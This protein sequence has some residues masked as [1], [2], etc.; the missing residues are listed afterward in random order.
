MAGIAFS[1]QRLMTQDRMSSQARGYLHATV[2]A[3][4]PWLLTAAAIALMLG[5]AKDLLS[6]VAQ[7]RFGSVSLLAF[8][9]SLVVASPLAMVLSRVLAD[10]IYVRDVRSVAPRLMQ[11]LAWAFVG[12]AAVAGALFGWWLVLP[13]P[14]RLLG[15]LL[16][17][18]CTGVWVTSSV[19]A[20]LR[21]FSTVTWGFALGLA[22]ALCVAYA[23]FDGWRGEALLLGLVVGLAVTF[24]VLLARVL[25]EFPVH[26]ATP[27]DADVPAALAPLS[28]GP[29]IARHGGL[30]LAGLLYALGLWVDEWIMGYAPGALTAGRGVHHHATYESAMFVASLAVI[31]AMVMLL[32]HLETQLHGAYQG[33]HREVTR[34]GTLR[35]IRRQHGSLLR[36]SGSALRR[37]MLLQ[38]TTVVLAWLAAPLLLRWLGGDE[39]LL[40]VL[41]FGL[42]GAA[43]HGVLIALLTALAYVDRQ[44]WMVGATLT[45]F[46]VNALATAMAA[47]LGP[48]YHGAGYAVA[49]LLAAVVAY[50][51]ASSTLSRLPYVTFVMANE[52]VRAPQRSRAD[53]RRVKAAVSARKAA[54]LS[55]PT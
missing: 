43:F 30:A 19:L 49:A 27:T 11:A 39:A 6:D 38:A 24:F 16:A 53:Q 33:Y 47:Q 52:A 2:V 23:G 14:Y 25:A 3:A 8:S 29:L 48:A 34:H 42:I 20:A 5:L 1:L 13:L 36:K 4:G 45:F 55:M 40:S 41:R 18:V 15:F 12:T 31:P 35:S 51:G 21:S 44:R 26:P 10:A 37:L 7:V 54:T 9:V 46:G 28:L 22:V 17:M 32:M 50:V